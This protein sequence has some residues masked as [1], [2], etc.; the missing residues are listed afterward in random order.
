MLRSL[1]MWEVVECFG[2]KVKSY[3]EWE[4]YG[5][6]TGIGLVFLYPYYKS[7]LCGN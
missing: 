7:N 2:T 6:K 3:K 1:G 4:N 5:K